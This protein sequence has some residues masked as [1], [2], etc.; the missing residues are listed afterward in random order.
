MIYYCHEA[1][2]IDLAGRF[3]SCYESGLGPG[4]DCGGELLVYLRNMCGL[5]YS[6]IAEIDF[7]RD[8]KFN[9]LGNLYGTAKKKL[10]EK[11]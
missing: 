9:F 5:K 8:L 11:N 1:G 6:Q 3:S 2:T 4:S 7:F 10:Q